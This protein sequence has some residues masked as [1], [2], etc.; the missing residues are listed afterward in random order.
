MFTDCMKSLLSSLG[1]LGVM[2]RFGWS[3]VVLCLIGMSGVG[4][5]PQR[6]DS[7]D[8]S[9][10]E[11]TNDAQASEQTRSALRASKVPL[12]IW[13]VG[14]MEQSEMLSRQWLSDSEQPIEVRIV[15]A[16]DL[17]SQQSVPADVLIYPSRLLGDLS[18]R[19]WIVKLPESLKTGMAATGTDSA[20]SLNGLPGLISATSYDGVQFGLSLGYSMLSLMGSQ[21][22]RFE[23]MTYLQLTE[24]LSELTAG[25]TVLAQNGSIDF[26]SMAVDR[27]ALVD[28]FLAIAF[29]LS[30]VNSKYGVLFEVRSMKSR[31]AK[32]EF[33]L[34]A[35]LLK[36]LTSQRDGLL[37]VVGSHSQALRWVHDCPTECY[38]F[39][40]ASELDLQS[41]SA[42][43]PKWIQW[44]QTKPW[45]SGA[46]MVVSITSQCRQTAQSIRF[47]EW[48]SQ[49]RTLSSLESH[50]PGVVSQSGVGGRL[51]DRVNQRN[52]SIFSDYNL[53]CEPRLPG[54]QRYRSALAEELL[55]ILDGRKTVDEGLQAAASAWD[56]ITGPGLPGL[57]NE[58]E[59]SL[60]M[61]L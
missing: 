58:Y 29:G 38:A 15:A 43:R 18:H 5:L 46:G 42:D 61:T 59:K 19:Q 28:R 9:T 54:V 1:P 45:N 60:G 32:E 4:C 24:R 55:A 34:A 47:L 6:A 12:R 11:S 40:S 49:P 56:A 16:E 21:S 26:S 39:V 2:P 51:V 37:S 7:D 41:Q 17:L 48:V 10:E 20:V 22:A 27:E 31:I 8:V 33:R 36:K 44:D 57:Q 35:E 23:K 53:S 52:A 50:L 3:L 14:R 25:D 13:I 30:P